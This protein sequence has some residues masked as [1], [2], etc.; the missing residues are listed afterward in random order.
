MLS[1][2]LSLWLLLFSP[3]LS[4]EPADWRAEMLAAVN[5]LRAQGCRCGGKYMAPA[6][7]LT[8][9]PQLTEAAQRHANDMYRHR[10]FSH[11][12]RNGSRLGERVSATGYRWRGVAE[13]IAHGQTSV[14]QVM[15]SWRNSPGH[16]RNLM[17]PDYR[18]FGIGYQDDYWVQVFARPW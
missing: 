18:H 6:P 10:Y 7:P 14:A 9:H 13:N 2:L 4:A 8:L 15:R 17:N 3:A 12:G 11:Q 16:C 5:E 1:L